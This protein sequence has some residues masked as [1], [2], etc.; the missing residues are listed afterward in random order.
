MNNSRK[1]GENHSQTCCKMIP[2]TCV[3]NGQE[4]EKLR[5][6]SIK[7]SGSTTNSA[8]QIQTCP[9][10]HY[11]ILTD[12]RLTTNMAEH[13]V[14]FMDELIFFLKSLVLLILVF[15]SEIHI[16]QCKQR[17]TKLVPICL[18]GRGQILEN[19]VVKS[20]VQGLNL[21]SATCQ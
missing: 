19:K 14:R 2:H 20:N 17:S 16:P 8:F 18:A 6:R 7:I 13:Q 11:F 5:N 4:I 9:M 15:H 12:L 1:M 3:L 10:N 21:S